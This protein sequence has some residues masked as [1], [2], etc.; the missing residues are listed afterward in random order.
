MKNDHSVKS[1]EA[2]IQKLEKLLLEKGELVSGSAH[3]IRTS[4]SASRWIIKMFLDGD[5]GKLTLE[6]EELM[7]KAYDDNLRAIEIISKLL[8]INK[9]EEIEE[10]KY[11]LEEISLLNLVDDCIFDFSGEAHSHEVEIIFLKPENHLSKILA[12]KEKLRI[13]L[14]NLL[15]NAIKYSDKKSKIFISLKEENKLIEFSI[16]NSGTV[17]SEEGKKRIFEK[18][19]RD[20]D[21][22]KREPSGTGIGL[23]TAK[24]I[25]ENH[26]GKM[27][28]ESEKGKGTTMFFAIPSIISSSK[29]NTC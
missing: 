11:N 18:F 7:Q 1:L 19:Y 12:D 29:E 22:K 14:Q 21:A 6:Q 26:K 16:K 8:L 17:I 25:V 3:Q 27:W 24:K 2:K 10:E 23:F 5:L 4:L 13:V 15:E 9:M 28:F 20:P